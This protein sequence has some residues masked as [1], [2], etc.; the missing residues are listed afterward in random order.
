M[1]DA[2]FFATGLKYNKRYGAGDSSSS[3][4]GNTLSN[5]CFFFAR[6]N[7]VTHSKRPIFN[8]LASFGIYE[9]MPSR[10]ILTNCTKN[11]GLL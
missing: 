8:S 4:T 7:S 2:C 1:I 11:N 6:L 5:I 3:G 10:K 9:M